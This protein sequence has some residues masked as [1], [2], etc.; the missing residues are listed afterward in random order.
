MGR[1]D[2][3]TERLVEE[4]L[5]THASANTQSAHRHDVEG[6][7]GWCGTTGRRPLAA[8]RADIDA[9]RDHCLSEPVGAATV[10]RRLSGIA[11]F[12]RYAAAVGAVTGDPLEG[13]DR[14]ASPDP[15]ASPVLDGDEIAALVA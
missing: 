15:T 13:V 8:R 9:Y 2:R 6:F 10:A 7:A 5:A 4:W 12:F 14:P 3:R 1:M 11:S